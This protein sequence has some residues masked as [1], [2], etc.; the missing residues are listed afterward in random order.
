[1]VD[2]LVDLQS[3]LAGQA[4]FNQ[5]IGQQDQAATPKGVLP[6]ILPTQDQR[7]FQR[8]Y[9]FDEGSQSLVLGE[10]I[11]LL[12]WTVPANEFWRPLALLYQNADSGT[13][14]VVTAFS[15]SRDPA[16]LVYQPSRTLIRQSS[17]KVIYGTVW[18]ASN[19]AANEQHYSSPIYV[20]ME[21][22]DRFDF[23]DES[24]NTGASVQRWIF[25]YEL[26]P[27]PST[28]RTPGVVAA[29]TVV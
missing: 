13:H 11:S 23:I 9:L 24:P 12:S 28:P 10:R 22:D 25:V 19:G 18:D 20:T 4:G 21:P 8:R 17:T 27:R 29:V 7:D 15:M 14:Q 5:W 2:Q 26:V 16:A 1:M 3:P 6:F